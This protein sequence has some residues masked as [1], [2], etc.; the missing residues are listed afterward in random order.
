MNVK[1]RKEVQE[2]KAYP[3]GK[4]ISEVKREYGLDEIVKLASNENPLG[5]SPKAMEAVK[6]LTGELNMYPDAAA[7]ELKTKIGR[8][9]G[10]NIDQ[11]FCGTGTDLLIRILCTAIINPGDECIVPEISFSR[12]NDSTQLMGGRCISIPLKNHCLDLEAM[13][14]AITPATKIIWFCNPNNPTGT[15]FTQHELDKI[16]DRIPDDVLIAMDEA[17]CEYV[18]AH[19]YPDSLSMLSQHP[20][21]VVLRTFSKVYGLAGLRVGYGICSPELAKYFNAVIGPFD[22]SLPAQAAAAAAIGDEE[23]VSR[24][25]EVNSLGKEYLYSEFDAMGLPYIR[26]QANF[27][28]VKVP[29]DD[30]KV[31]TELLKRG[32]IVKAG[33]ALGMPGY[34]RVSIG[35]RPQNEK[36]IEALFQILKK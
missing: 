2:L 10:A 21:M 29:D 8:R 33:S 14:E 3:A 23:F 19:D 18:T 32:I 34:L 12:Y 31:F 1:V 20:N 7:Y 35:T 27:L 16:I 30:R 11:I 28:M 6:R 36:F 17:Y 9:L 5:C 15:I 26:T 22:V 25:R 24:S 13:V 4:P